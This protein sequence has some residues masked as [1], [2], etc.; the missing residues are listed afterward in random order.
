MLERWHKDFSECFK[1][2][3]DDPELVFDDDFLARVTKLKD[4]FDVLSHSEQE[5]KSPFDN[6]NLNC[7]ISYQEVSNAID[8]SKLCKAYLA[9]PNEA[10][11]NPAAKLLLHKFFNKCFELLTSS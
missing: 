1:G 5:S 7:E 9:I 3:K 4:D 11:K 6:V 10:L 8:Q 2:I